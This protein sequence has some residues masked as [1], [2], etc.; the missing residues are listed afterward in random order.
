MKRDSR[1]RGSTK[2]SFHGDQPYEVWIEGVSPSERTND[3]AA[4][5]LRGRLGSVLHYLA[6]AAEKAD[7][8]VEYVHLLRVWTRRAGAAVR[9]YKKLIPRR[10]HSWLKKQL[11]RV[12]RA[13]NDA[14]N[15]DVLLER[16]A[17]EQPSDATKRCLKLVR[18]ERAEA[19][20][21]VVAVYER[22]WHGNE[23]MRRLERLVERVESRGKK[24]HSSTDHF[25]DWA[26]AHFRPVVERFFAALPTDKTD[27]LALHQFRICNKELCYDMELL[28][29]A[30]PDELRTRL[31]PSI[32]VIQDRQGEI[33]D[34]ATAKTRIQDKIDA[35][36]DPTEVAFWRGLLANEQ[37]KVDGACQEFWKFCTPEKLRD[38][39]EEFDKML[40][41]PTQLEHCAVAIGN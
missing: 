33:I 19:Q 5:A 23:S 7:E 15:C 27:V 21:G 29:G 24:T 10:R 17:K 1:L 8:D 39:R 18:A 14:R 9:L 20:A 3:V 41:R 32:L 34:L 28:T 6:L 12:R 2:R 31:Y 4:R 37:L 36:S 38:L 40:S 26:H 16:L 22:L 35:A 11:K 13:A 30:F 25:G